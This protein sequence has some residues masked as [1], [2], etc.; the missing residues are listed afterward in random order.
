MEVPNVPKVQVTKTED[1]GK[2]K[3][4]E[5]VRKPSANSVGESQDSD[6]LSLSANARTLSTLRSAF[7]K[8]PGNDTTVQEIKTKIVESGPATLSSE[9]IVAGILHGT[10]FSVL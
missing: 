10:L 7:D 4:W 5:A 8:L 1:V 6:K 2:V 9:E 3:S